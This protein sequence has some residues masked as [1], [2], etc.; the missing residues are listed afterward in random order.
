MNQRTDITLLLNQW[1]AGDQAALS[2]V[3]PLVYDELKK[4]AQRIFARE[5]AAHTLQPTALVN[6]AYEK[7]IG[8][9]AEWQDRAHFY[10]LAARMMRR[11]LVNHANS[12][13]AQ[14]RGGD[15]LKVTLHEE[16]HAGQSPDEDLL[17]LDAALAELANNDERKSLVLELH[18]FGGLTHEQTAIAL[19]VS[20]STVRRELR[21]AKIWLK[22]ALSS[23]AESE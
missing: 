14:K 18:Y 22:K 8:V 2:S 4:M 19:N 16:L 9:N 7:L 5:S 21:V 6:E 13:R 3:T 11:L 20:E 1:V 23:D 17:E 10:A 12:R 15:A